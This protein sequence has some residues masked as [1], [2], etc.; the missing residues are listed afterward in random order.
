MITAVL[1]KEVFAGRFASRLFMTGAFVILISLGAFVRIPLPFT[2]VP[3][4]LQTFFV[5]LSAAMLGAGWG[6]I[7]QGL[8]V[9]SGAS[10]LAVFAQ[11]GTGLVYF[12]GPTGGYLAGFIAAALF[13]GSFI[14]AAEKNIIAL[15][16]LFTAASMIILACGTLWLKYLSASS[17]QAAFVIGFLPFII[18]DT[19]KAVCAALVYAKLRRKVREVLG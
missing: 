7:V 13:T 4:T 15:S 12:L 14:R 11:G 19:L 17:L 8:Y 18:G 5:L 6:G 1:K 16:A 10:G 2:P 9:L 3:L